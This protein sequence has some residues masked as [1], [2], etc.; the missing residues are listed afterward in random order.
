MRYVICLG[1]LYLEC[2]SRQVKAAHPNTDFER[3]HVQ[4]RRG[5][6]VLV[7]VWP[8]CQII[9]KGSLVS[10]RVRAVDH[11]NDFIG[12]DYISW[13]CAGRNG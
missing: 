10:K 8:Y 11:R 9:H 7:K 3:G 2:E 12:S 5:A 13:G 1:R 6:A 4:G